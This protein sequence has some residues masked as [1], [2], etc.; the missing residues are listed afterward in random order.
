M[1][2]YMLVIKSLNRIWVNIEFNGDQRGP[3]MKPFII[4]I[5][6]QN[7]IYIIQRDYITI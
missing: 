1:T 4:C 5:K 6:Y 7:K 2:E 3:F